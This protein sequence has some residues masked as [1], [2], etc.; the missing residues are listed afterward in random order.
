M[1]RTGRE[2]AVSHRPQLPAQRLLGDR[3]GKLV[4]QPLHEIPNPPAHHPVNS[5]DGALVEGALE[6]LAVRVAED[7]L[8]ARCPAG[9]QWTARDD[10]S[11][12]MIS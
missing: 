4:P 11:G 5:R 12:F 8:G 10:W 9:H 7:R 3:D 1:T 2:L 6:R